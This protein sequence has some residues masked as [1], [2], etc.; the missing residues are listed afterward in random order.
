M[1]NNSEQ[2]IEALPDYKR[3]YSDMIE[4]K[5]PEKKEICKHL[6]LKKT[7]STFDI[8]EISKILF[9]KSSAENSE[10]NQMH[11]YYNKSTIFQILEYQKKNKL[12]NSELAKHFKLS[13]NTVTKW[14]KQFLL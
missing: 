9:N 8:I 14:K 13:R 4:L 5:Y 3:I 12:N 1:K 7:L 11:R 10:F 2:I 6:L